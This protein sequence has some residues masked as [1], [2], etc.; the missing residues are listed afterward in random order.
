[1]ERP[2]N[3]DE[4]LDTLVAEVKLKVSELL[5]LNIEPIN[6]VIDRDFL[7]E[8]QYARKLGMALLHN[9]DE[10]KD[11]LPASN[12]FALDLFAFA[13]AVSEAGKFMN[14]LPFDRDASAELENRVENKMH[15]STPKQARARAEVCKELVAELQESTEKL[16]TFYRFVAQLLG[17]PLGR[18]YETLG[19][20]INGEQVSEGD[21]AKKAELYLTR[22]I[23]LLEGMQGII[24]ALKLAGY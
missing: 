1:M 12:S 17:D 22:C 19:W 23:N 13:V 16:Q 4:V 21:Q 24:Y 5:K 7:E 15:E 11:Y 9:I 20:E 18:F 2:E 10:D 6:A 3:P 8:L 14:T